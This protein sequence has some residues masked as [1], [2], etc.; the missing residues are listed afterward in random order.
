[1]VVRVRGSCPAAP[2]STRRCQVDCAGRACGTTGSVRARLRGPIPARVDE[3]QP[4]QPAARPRPRQQRAD[5]RGSGLSASLEP[6]ARPRTCEASGEAGWLGQGRVSCPSEGQ[7]FRVEAVAQDAEVR[8]A[9]RNRDQLAGDP[10][11]SIVERSR[12][13]TTTQALSTGTLSRSEARRARA[14]LA[15][16][17]GDLHHSPQPSRVHAPADNAQNECAWVVSPEGSFMEGP[18]RTLRGRWPESGTTSSLGIFTSRNTRRSSHGGHP[19]AARPPATR[20]RSG[21]SVY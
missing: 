15:R 5:T 16:V 14:S 3:H 8:L 20:P 7:R 18:C 1:M 19:Y 17:Q 4:S 6:Y 10:H 13:T 11:I 21:H 9:Q 2:T 12:P